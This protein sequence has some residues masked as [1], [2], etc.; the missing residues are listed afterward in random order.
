MKIKLFLLLLFSLLVSIKSNAFNFGVG[1]D[2]DNGG[3][4]AY[5]D[6]GLFG[7]PYPYNW[8]WP[9]G[10]AYPPNR[11]STCRYYTH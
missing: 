5:E 6:I 9:Q 7:D 11:C 3:S 8:Y 4:S 2:S 10:P 1:F